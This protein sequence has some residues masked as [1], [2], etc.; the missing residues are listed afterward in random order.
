MI[1]IIMSIYNNEKSLKKSIESVLRQSFKNF[2]FII[3]DDGSEDKS[4]EILEFYN[5]KDS[6]IK[7][8]KNSTNL[9]LPKSLNKALQ[10][11]RF[12]YIGRFDADDICIPSRFEK[13]IKYLLKNPSIDILGSNAILIDSNGT[14][15]GKVN[16]PKTNYQITKKL[17][18]QNCMIHP[19]ILMKKSVIKDVGGYNENLLKAQ[20]FDL[21]SRAIE[22]GKIFHN[23]EECLI[24]YNLELKK[25]YK[26]IFME[27]KTAI[28]ISLRN[29]SL[30]PILWAG[31]EFARHFI[32]KT[33]MYTP[34]NLRK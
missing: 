34:K 11:A 4:L 12:D 27:F 3:I 24:K 23:L 22:K 32:I 25:P 5:K 33:N 14:R 18:Y 31:V 16:L 28:L 8:L 2:E 10:I 13:Q 21:W 26:T 30:K 1:S 9:G 7:I 15:I 17:R 6:R 20:D 19:S 29:K